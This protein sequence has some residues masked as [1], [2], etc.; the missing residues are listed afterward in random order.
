M[1][2]KIGLDNELVRGVERAVFGPVSRNDIDAWVEKH[3][4]ARLGV[5]ISGFVF[6][7]GRVAAVYGAVLGDGRSVAV[8][9]HRRPVNVA[10]LSA[11][12]AC[13]RRLADAGFPC[14]RPLDGPAATDDLTTVIE[15]L[16]ADGEPGD[17]HKPGVRLAVARSLFEHIDLLRGHPVDKLV[18]GAPAWSCYEHGPWPEP[19]D[20]IFDF[21]TTPAGFGWLDDLARRAAAVLGDAG[22][23]ELIAHADWSCGNLRFHGGKVSSSY[24]WD[25]LA[26][27]PEAVLVGLC[28]GGFTS[29]G[30][31]GADTPTPDEMTAFLRDYED[32]RAD[33]F[34][35]PQQKAAAAAITWVL[36]YN[37][38][39][40]ASFMPPGGLPRVGFPLEAISTHRDTLLALRW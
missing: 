6:R 32:V 36:A 4:R 28:A 5:A 10:Y 19:H 18:G 1:G 35:E 15:T 12:I 34:N 2:D 29:G 22:P 3:V 27:A 7:S 38:R 16:V 37:G 25:S 30:G 31:A 21:T 26:V 17:G 20:P 33:P 40:E 39:C 9:V 11:A 14:P 24:D 23:P 13:Q 8:K